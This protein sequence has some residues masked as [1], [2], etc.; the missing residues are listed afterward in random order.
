MKSLVTGGSGYFGEIMC[1]RLTQ[2]GHQV[3]VLDVIENKDR[4]REYTFY[5]TDIRSYQGVKEAVKGVDFVFHNVAQVPLAKDDELFLSVNIDGTR[6]LLEACLAERVKKVVYTSSSAVFGV[7][8][9]N[10]VT[11]LTIPLP[12]ESYGAAKLEGKSYVCNM[13]VRD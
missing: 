4:P 11:E 7:P 9:S 13:S 5:Q 10:P 3:S 8:K 6:N 2:L 1:K 12:G